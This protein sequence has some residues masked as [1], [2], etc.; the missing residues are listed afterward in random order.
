MGPLRAGSPQVLAG[1]SVRSSWSLCLVSRTVSPS[2]VSP[3]PGAAATWA[4]PWLLPSWSKQ[5]QRYLP[6]PCTP[7][8]G[9]CMA[10][11]VFRWP[12]AVTRCGGNI[13][14][15]LRMVGA[16][17][18]TLGLWPLLWMGS[19]LQ[20]S[21]LRGHSGLRE[22]ELRSSGSVAPSHCTPTVRPEVGGVTSSLVARK[23][24]NK[25]MDD[26]ERVDL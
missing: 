25:L 26:L 17:L 5:L 15:L 14:G 9:G 12:L 7:G 23:L 21:Q 19:S 18:C 8:C 3:A 22:S 4:S 1:P 16:A 13:D 24:R 6:F 10:Q 11:G 20:C 2:R